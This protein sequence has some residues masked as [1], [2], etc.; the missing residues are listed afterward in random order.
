MFSSR[1]AA[2]KKNW[3][4]NDGVKVNPINCRLRRFCSCKWTEKVNK[5]GKNVGNYTISA[6]FLYLNLEILRKRLCVRVHSH[7]AR[8]HFSAFGPSANLESTNTH[9]SERRE[10]REN[11]Q[12]GGRPLLCLGRVPVL[13]VL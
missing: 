13:S 11:K 12:S 4:D 3:P 2:R 10:S 7:T 9:G 5:E 1:V 6:T 8:S